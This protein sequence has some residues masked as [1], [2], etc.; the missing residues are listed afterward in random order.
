MAQ[1]CIEMSG[2][3][4]GCLISAAVYLQVSNINLVRMLTASG[5]ASGDNAI[6]PREIGPA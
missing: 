3:W 4:E 1:S 6:L 5:S 2:T